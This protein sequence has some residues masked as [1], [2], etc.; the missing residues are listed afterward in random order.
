[1]NRRCVLTLLGAAAAGT[2]LG[3]HSPYRQW[4]LYRQ[5]HLLLLTMR[6]DPRSDELGELLAAALRERLPD[7]RAQ[8]ARAP[9]AQRIA[10]LVSSRQADV[11][12]LRS[13]DARALYRGEGAFAHY[14]KV[15]L[16]VLVQVETYRVICRDDFRR[17]HAYAVAEALSAAP[18]PAALHVPL[19]VA[20]GDVPTH[21]GA[22][23]F[24]RGEPVTGR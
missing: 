6:E 19:S 10:S 24:A 22:L 4:K 12:I 15:P 3:G 18:R 23:A 8:V 17:E 5:A 13:E 20:V 7:S 2:L 1:M 16:R 21:E 11:G 9:H 14:G